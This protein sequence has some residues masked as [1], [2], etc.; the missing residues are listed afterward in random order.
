M[1]FNRRPKVNYA[2]QVATNP[3]TIVLFTNGPEL[4]DN[5]YRRY[6]IRRCAINSSFPKSPSSSISAA[7]RVAMRPPASSIPKIPPY[8]AA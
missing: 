3:P 5:S 4:F 1:R 7:N 6:L 8:N 2:T